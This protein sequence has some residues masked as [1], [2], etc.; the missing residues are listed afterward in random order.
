MGFDLLEQFPFLW[1]DLLERLLEVWL[2]GGIAA[3]AIA[4]GGH[5]LLE[6]Q[7]VSAVL[8]CA[9]AMANTLE[10][11]RAREAVR[12]DN[13]MD[14]AGLFGRWLQRDGLKQEYRRYWTM[15]TVVEPRRK[16][17]EFISFRI[18][19]ADISFSFSFSAQAVV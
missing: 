17:A 3:G 14:A 19:F 18:V 12:A 13:A 1:N 11:L 9:I 8:S 16:T 15:D 4:D 6:L 5:A 2:R 10:A 7:Q